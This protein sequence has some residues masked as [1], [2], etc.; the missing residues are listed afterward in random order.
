MSSVVLNDLTNTFLKIFQQNKT[1]FT[2]F[3]ILPLAFLFVSSFS[4]NSFANA[5]KSRDQSTEIL[6]ISNM[7]K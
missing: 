3:C 5:D 6:E 2:L 1:K 4:F 7:S